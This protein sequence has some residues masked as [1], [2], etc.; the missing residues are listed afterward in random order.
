M[1]S[2]HERA[3][4]FVDERGVQNPLIEERALPAGYNYPDEIYAAHEHRPD[5]GALVFLD[6]F[7]DPEEADQAAGTTG[8]V[9]T[10]RPDG[11]AVEDIH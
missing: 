11:K 3:L 10:L 5:E 1:F 9:L 4:T 6:L 7:I 8:K 2:T